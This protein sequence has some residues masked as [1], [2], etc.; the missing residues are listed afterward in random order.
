MARISPHGTRAR[1]YWH[2]AHD[3]TPCDLCR[4]ANRTYAEQRRRAAGA[5]PLAED[6]EAR[7]QRAE[8][9]HP[10]GTWQA[11]ARHYK[12]GEK[13]CEPCRIAYNAHY[14]ET[15]KARKEQP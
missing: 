3:E 9:E 11:A 5:K 1:Y 2:L 15:R 14:R 8:T 6:I 10:H 7:R 12:H 13:P 4:E